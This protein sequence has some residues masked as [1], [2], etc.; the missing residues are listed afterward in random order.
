MADTNPNPR[1]IWLF[2]NIPS[3]RFDTLCIA[4][5]I[6]LVADNTYDWIGVRDLSNISRCNAPECWNEGVLL[7]AS[8]AL[9]H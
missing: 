6:Y 4:I 3:S 1:G 2:R 5:F 7:G 8:V 9:Q